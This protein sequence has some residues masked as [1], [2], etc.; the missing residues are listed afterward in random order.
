MN[1]PSYSY[2]TAS[3]KAKPAR[4]PQ[5]HRAEERHPVQSDQLAEGS[6]CCFRWHRSGSLGTLVEGVE[7][8][9]VADVLELVEVEPAGLLVGC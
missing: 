6:G 1:E 5:P 7:E 3:E 4:Q 2:S 8:L 9:D